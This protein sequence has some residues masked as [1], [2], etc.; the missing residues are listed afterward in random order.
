VRLGTLLWITS[1]VDGLDH[2]VADLHPG[3]LIGRCGTPV[4][5]VALTAPSGPPCGACLGAG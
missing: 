2:V 4:L 1:A 5:P 3:H